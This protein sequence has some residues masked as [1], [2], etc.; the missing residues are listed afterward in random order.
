MAKEKKTSSIVF[1]LSAHGER[2]GGVEAAG[3]EDNNFE[4]GRLAIAPQRGEPGPPLRL[5]NIA[6]V[7]SCAFGAAVDRPISLRQHTI[8]TIVTGSLM[9]A[10]SV[11]A[12]SSS[13]S[14]FS[15]LPLSNSCVLPAREALSLGVTGSINLTTT[16]G[17][18]GEGDLTIPPR[19]SKGVISK[20]SLPGRNVIKPLIERVSCDDTLACTVRGYIFISPVRAVVVP[21]P[22]PITWDRTTT[23]YPPPVPPSHGRAAP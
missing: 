7:E 19:T 12:R 6:V 8:L 4:V 18:R 15:C 1:G 11:S 16:K 22:T 21:Q 3:E 2:G 9:F 23:S 20:Q 14:A 5:L 13:S 17:E 10:E